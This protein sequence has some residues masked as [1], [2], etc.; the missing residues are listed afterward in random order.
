M[1]VARVLA[2]L[3]AAWA[4]ARALA[5][6]AGQEASRR[7]LPVYVGL[8]AVAGLLFG[9]NGLTTATV[10]EGAGASPLARAL[11]WCAWLIALAPTM[12]A[13]WQSRS[14]LW[15]RS[16]PA[17]RGW[18][19]AILLGFSLVA[20]SLWGLLWALG[21]GPVA[22]AGALGGA[23]AGHG[24]LLARP[25]GA[26]GW[27]AVMA[28]VAGLVLAPPLVL[29]VVSWPIALLALRAAWLAAP[30]RSS[31][32]RG[33]SR[34]LPGPWML[35]QAL[36][37]SVARGHATVLA[38][39]ALMMALA[40]AAAWLAARTN[41]VRDPSG[42]QHY[43]CG[44][45]VPAGLVAGSAA[46]G[47]LLRLEA[48]ALWLLRTAGAS[49]PIRR[50]AMA[51]ALAGLG[52]GLGV[53]SA[54]ALALATEWSSAPRLLLAGGLAGASLLTF[55]GLAGRWTE[56]FGSRG[57]GRLVL[58]LLLAAT[59]ALAT[60]AWQPT[61]A[62]LAWAL[63]VAVIWLFGHARSVS[64]DG[65]AAG[66]AAVVLAM[67]GVRKR[68]GTRIVLEE[69]DLRCAAGEVVLL[70][71]ENGAGKSTLLR[72]A[73]GLVE[74]DRGQVTV[75]GAALDGGAEGRRALAYAPDT[76]D[77]FP[78]LGVRELLALVAVIKRAPPPSPALCER[79]GLTPVM[80][81]RMRTLSFGQ[82]K[83]T[84]LAAATIG[85]PPL[86]VLDEPSNG[87]D[88]AGG[89]LMAT[90]LREHAA[91]GGAA[92]VATNDARFVGLCAGRTVRLANGRLREE[93]T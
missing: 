93:P 47:P 53:A 71:G 14:S 37:T 33:L 55:A 25:A 17:R 10:V 72:I 86:W 18:H 84:Y 58:V 79:L 62:M 32:G 16:L 44:F 66:G 15:L 63:A 2:E 26:R 29:A 23:L 87:L 30:T 80:E 45:M 85:A 12:A 42:L 39:G 74:P 19:L 3:P 90:M 50:G 61:L 7:G 64:R 75:A 8:V 9:G 52:A 20:E 35:A 89:A 27:A 51:L 81:Q 77:A 38:R 43:L 69:I 34:R 28:V 31:G 56:R 83:R 54:A 67:I 6:T 78:D 36:L 4:L 13:L 73:A 1:A 68:L 5:L 40:T 59:L 41:A 49:G 88:P 60:L 21:G 22:A 11:L 24:V 92:L 65:R 57:P 76:A 48:G 70:L 91:A 46:S 82:V